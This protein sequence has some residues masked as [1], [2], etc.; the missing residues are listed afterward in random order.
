MAS[1]NRSLAILAAVP[2]L[3][4]LAGCA[5]STGTRADR[6]ATAAVA[7]A[8]PASPAKPARP[9]RSD[10]AADAKTFAEAVQR[11][12]KAWQANELDRAVYY[13]V[14]A[15]ERSPQDA[16]TL[17]KIGAIKQQRGETALAEKAFEMAHAAQPDEPRIAER[18]A[19]LYMQ[20]DKVDSAARIYGEVLALHPQRARSLD[21]MGEVCILRAQYVQS[22]QYFDQA[23]QADKPDAASVLTHRGYAKLRALDLPG[24]EADLRAALAVTPR[25]DAWRYLADL[26]VRQ[27]DN[28]GALASLL[29]IMDSAHAY[30]EI[31]VVLLN[32][33]RYGDSRV[34]F[35]KAINASPTWYEEA[36]RNLELAEENLRGP[37]DA[38][39]AAR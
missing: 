37:A 28:A 21:G 2:L 4:Q 25:P 14:L 1:L 27:H 22:I 23:L 32:M 18:L 31:G 38:V 6:N 19:Q 3:L 20:Q 30:N 5:S 15:L 26:Q 11:G 39:G 24:A 33:N 35:A 29:K 17:A 8:A 34:Y 16:P 9:I 7:P 13:Y 12:D 10:P 36:Q